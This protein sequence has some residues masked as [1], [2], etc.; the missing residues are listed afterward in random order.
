MNIYIYI[1]LF[2]YD[3]ICIGILW[4]LFTFS[5]FLVRILEA[6]DLFHLSDAKFPFSGHR[7][8]RGL[9]QTRKC[10]AAPQTPKPGGS[11]KGLLKDTKYGIP[12]IASNC[13]K[14][15]L[16]QAKRNIHGLVLI[17]WSFLFLRWSFWDEVK[18]FLWHP[19]ICWPWWGVQ[20]KVT[21][22]ECIP[23]SWWEKMLGI[24]LLSSTLTPL[25]GLV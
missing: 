22:Y 1:L 19:G 5:I 14:W 9:R 12:T 7:C 4:R 24:P 16:I 13:K 18:F 20:Q 10:C 2:I 23:V 6:L 17:N 3:Y 25:V 15:N 21:D 11:R 8:L